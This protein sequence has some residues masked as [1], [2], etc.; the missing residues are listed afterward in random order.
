MEWHGKSIQWNVD[1]G[2]CLST[3]AAVE[4]H[5]GGIF[6]VIPAGKYTLDPNGGADLNGLSEGFKHSSKRFW[7]EGDSGASGNHHCY[8]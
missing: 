5:Q 6:L 1:G 3:E 2:P 4:V 7:K 8:R